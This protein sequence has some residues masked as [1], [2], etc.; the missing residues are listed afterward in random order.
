[1]KLEEIK[2]A[3]DKVSD[4]LKE[5]NDPE[6]AVVYKEVL[7]ALEL[8]A[9][10]DIGRLVTALENDKYLP[11]RQR[12]MRSQLEDTWKWGDSSDGGLTNDILRKLTNA[13]L[14]PESLLEGMLAQRQNSFIKLAQD[15]GVSLDKVAEQRQKSVILEAIEKTLAK[16]KTIG[17]IDT[18]IKKLDQKT[19]KASNKPIDGL[20]CGYIFFRYGY[21]KA[22][23]SERK[24]YQEQVTKVDPAQLK[25][26]QEQ[27]AARRALV[28]EA[29]EERS[30]KI[31][32]Q[33]QLQAEEQRKAAAATAEAAR[34]KAENE[35]WEREQAAQRRIDAENARD[36]KKSKFGGEFFTSS[37]ANK[38]GSSTASEVGEKKRDVENS[39]PDGP[40]GEKK[41]RKKT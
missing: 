1:M 17:E 16:I 10:G 36:K 3:R 34:V 38:G 18:N 5:K 24:Q 33:R 30:K 23:E 19:N 22:A 21:Y 20:V 40:S 41:R 35:M 25:I 7:A 12:P 2:I 37:H 29:M 14:T 8:E 4:L 39:N 6:M 11:E 27:E 9:E 32:I 13:N 28:E 26:L 31:A 15:L